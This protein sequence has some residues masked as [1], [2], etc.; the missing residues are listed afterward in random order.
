M[1]VVEKWNNGNF[2]LSLTEPVQILNDI[3]GPN[4]KNKTKFRVIRNKLLS[5]GFSHS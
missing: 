3:Q 2:F 4:R 5:W 1:V